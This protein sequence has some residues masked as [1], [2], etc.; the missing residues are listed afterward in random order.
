VVAAEAAAKSA[1]PAVAIAVAA[2]GKAHAVESAE[3]PQ[4]YDLL[5][6]AVDGGRLVWRRGHAEKVADEAPLTGHALRLRKA[7]HGFLLLS[8]MTVGGLAL[9]GLT[10]IPQ[11]NKGGADKEYAQ[12]LIIGEFSGM[13]ALGTVGGILWW[14]SNGLAKSGS[15]MRP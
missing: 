2:P 7:A 4:R 3:P 1:V 5:A 11:Q 13:V 9:T 15:G 10:S 8:G 6:P 14:V 12:G